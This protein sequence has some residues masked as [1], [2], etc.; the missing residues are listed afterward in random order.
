MP[1]GAQWQLIRMPNGPLIRLELSIY[2]RPDLPFRFESFLNIADRE[3]AQIL[4]R[5]ANQDRLGFAFFGDN[6]EHQLS[7]TLPHTEQ[8]WQQLDGIVS[9]ANDY[10]NR[11]PE[12][13]RDFDQA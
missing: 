6:L 2:D 4:D 11:L 9:Q 7:C 13:I 1:A 10:L 8:Q 12:K 5:L 3:Q